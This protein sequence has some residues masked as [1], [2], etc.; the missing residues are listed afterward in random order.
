MNNDKKTS[1]KKTLEWY[2]CIRK[3]MHP[4]LS[5]KLYRIS[6]IWEKDFHMPIKN[7]KKRDNELEKKI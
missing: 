4:L 5:L 3:Q 1:G 7:K 2:L 6:I